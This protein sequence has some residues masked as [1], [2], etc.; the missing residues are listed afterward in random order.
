ME[1]RESD[2]WE[3]RGHMGLKKTMNCSHIPGGEVKGRAKVNWLQVVQTEHSYGPSTARA[4]TCLI[5]LDRQQKH[6]RY[7]YCHHFTE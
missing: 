6:N 2:L 7:N 3:L 5:S 1:V 4:F